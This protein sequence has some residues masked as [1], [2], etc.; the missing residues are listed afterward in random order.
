M[1]K[2]IAALCVALLLFA[3]TLTA[4]DDQTEPKAKAVKP[5]EIDAKGG[6]PA[7]RGSHDKPTVI[8]TEKELAAQ[9]SNEETRAAILK[10][11]DF[12]KEQLLLFSW[13]GSGG[14]KLTP[15]EGKAGEAAFEF[16]PGFTD[17]F[18]RHAKLFAVPAKSKLK[19]TKRQE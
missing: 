7:G 8:T 17:D 19:I 4:A 6:L 15:V 11:V 3:A 9:V 12:K 18:V 2:P 10:K 14:D 13:A 16:R 1:P 5:R